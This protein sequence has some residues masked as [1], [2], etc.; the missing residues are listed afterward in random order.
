MT[1]HLF[2][3]QVLLWYLSG[4][5]RLPQSV[6]DIVADTRLRRCVSLSSLW[7]IAVKERI[8]KLDPGTLEQVLNRFDEGFEHL[9]VSERHVRRYVNMQLGGSVHRDPFDLILIAQAMEEELVLVTFD[10][11]IRKMPVS[12]LP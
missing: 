4:D 3:T 10:A 11:E 9:A 6:R 1:G 2:D 5:A 8:G 7:E 12:V